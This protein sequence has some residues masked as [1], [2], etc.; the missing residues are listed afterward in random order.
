[1]KIRQLNIPM[2][3]SALCCCFT[4][5]LT[6]HVNAQ[7]VNSASLDPSYNLFENQPDSHQALE[8]IISKPR[9]AQ[10]LAPIALYPDTL[11][12]HI[13][14]ASTYPLQ[15]VQAHRWQQKYQYLSKKQL[16]KKASNKDW[17]PSVVTLVA[18]PSVLERLSED[19]DWTQELG[20]AFLQNEQRV[21]A[22]I[23]TLRQ[24]A[25][26][27]SS[28]N[29]MENM[30]VKY[31]DSQI[32]IEPRYREV[33]YVPYYDPRIVYGSWRWHKYPPIYWDAPYYAGVHINLDHQ[34]R[35]DHRH[36]QQHFYWGTGIQINFNYFFSA[37][38]WRK[39]HIVVTSHRNSHYYRPK[40]RIITSH[41]AKRWHKKPYYRTERHTSH[42]SGYKI[43]NG[44]GLHAKTKNSKSVKIKTSPYSRATRNT[45]ISKQGLS[46]N[47]KVNKRHVPH[48]VHNNSGRVIVT[49]KPKQVARYKAS[50]ARVN[51]SKSKIRA[52]H[53]RS[54]NKNYSKSFNKSHSKT[55]HSDR[56]KIR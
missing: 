7:A 30:S 19:L 22:S 2:I 40:H 10:I 3:L 23:Q 14:I 50:P 56:Q 45:Q 41:G 16:L 13:L 6:S 32:I 27:A 34:H 21:L 26:T 46:H 18:F 38:H 31:V 52:V 49:A 17:E 1:M 25:D 55:R 44:S 43:H 39:Q 53:Q 8:Q 12:S 54:H 4:S 9:L 48:K 36:S 35:H 5:L 20:H 29:D 11:L 47:R 42:R 33:I 28:L 15:I 24:Q 37:F 51:K